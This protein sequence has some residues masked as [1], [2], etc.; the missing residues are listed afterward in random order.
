MAQ[1]KTTEVSCHFCEKKYIFTS[2]EV[3]GFA[4]K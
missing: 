1:E 4:E 2:E 3:L